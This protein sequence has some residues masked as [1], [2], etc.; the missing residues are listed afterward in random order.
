MPV[1]FFYLRL[2]FSYPDF[3][4]ITIF[5]SIPVFFAKQSY[6]L[7]LSNV[8]RLTGVLTSDN[9]VMIRL[10]L[11]VRRP[12]AYEF[13]LEQM[14]DLQEHYDCS[15]NSGKRRCIVRLLTN[16]HKGNR[17]RIYVPF[18]NRYLIMFRSQ[19]KVLK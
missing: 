15:S 3:F 9:S 16:I 12:V 7:S 11:W 6:S 14:I 4:P 1:R 5:I 2:T 19:T 8:I 17:D 10:S 18:W 13:G